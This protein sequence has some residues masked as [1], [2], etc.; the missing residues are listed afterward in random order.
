MLPRR[1]RTL[2][3]T[4][5]A[6]ALGVAPLSACGAPAFH[7]PKSTEHQTYLK[8]PTSW[9]QID[10]ALVEEITFGD[11]DSP[12][13][14]ALRDASWTVAYD[15]DPEPDVTHLVRGYPSDAPNVH[16]TALALDEETR[17]A[18][19]Y[20]VLRDFRL[21][22]TPAARQA[23][24]QD[25]QFTFSDFELLTE[26]LLNP[27][28]GLHGV[29][30]VFNYRSPLGELQTYDQTALTNDAADVLYLLEVR[31]SAKCYQQRVEEIQDVVASFTV[32]SK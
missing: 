18:I 8:V 13:S 11:L 29:R 5:L 32:R 12:S 7:Y 20:D 1:H 10:Q 21:P 24:T 4:L 31:C 30:V 2:V 19:S 23:A 26:E 14:R 16:A 9:A 17:G 27:E 22:V 3:T 28:P 15:A 25:P 6:A